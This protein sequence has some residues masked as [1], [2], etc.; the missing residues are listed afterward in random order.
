[1][2]ISSSSLDFTVVCL[3]IVSALHSTTSILK[4][5]RLF[6]GELRE[7]FHAWRDFF[8]RK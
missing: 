7:E 5:I 6:A 8:R 4:L 2:E 1:M 3:A